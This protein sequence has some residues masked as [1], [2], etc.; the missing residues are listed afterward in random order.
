MSRRSRPLRSTWRK[1]ESLPR[2]TVAHIL[3]R[4]HGPWGGWLP[5]SE[6]PRPAGGGGHGQ[7]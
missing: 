3:W 4:R 6:R 2:E 5:R 1:V 7:R